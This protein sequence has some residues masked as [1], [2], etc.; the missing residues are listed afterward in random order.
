M[1]P[2]SGKVGGARVRPTLLQL[3]SKTLKA[4]KWNTIYGLIWP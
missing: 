1:P 3:P 4:K 2:F